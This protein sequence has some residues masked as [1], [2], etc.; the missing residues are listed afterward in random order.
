M[1]E[2]LSK[3]EDSLVQTIKLKGKLFH[4]YKEGTAPDDI[5]N[6]G[7]AQTQALG[8]VMVIQQESQI[9]TYCA[10]LPKVKIKLPKNNLID[11]DY[12][13]FYLG[14]TEG[15]ESTRDGNTYY[16][17]WL[18]VAAPSNLSYYYLLVEFGVA[19]LRVR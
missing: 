4:I 13:L 5:P 17:Y 2:E 14:H 7:S 10:F 19:K 15:K 16:A 11:S 6:L 9:H 3:T 12:E 1:I 18:H 8:N